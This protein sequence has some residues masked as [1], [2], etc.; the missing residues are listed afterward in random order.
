MQAYISPSIK[1]VGSVKELTQS[2]FL[3]NGQ[4]KWNCI[5]PIFGS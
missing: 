1:E 4:D 3:S 2:Q 5:I